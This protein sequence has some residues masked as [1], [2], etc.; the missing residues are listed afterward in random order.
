MVKKTAKTVWKAP[1]PQGRVW[2]A[3]ALWLLPL[4]AQA[5]PRCVDATPYKSGLQ[6][7]I[8]VLLPLPFALGYGLYWFLRRSFPAETK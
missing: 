4:A 6:L 2:T 3:M 7:A 1:C 5:C 8:A